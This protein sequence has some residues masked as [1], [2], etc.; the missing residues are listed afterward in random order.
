MQFVA[1]G[2]DVPE[3]LLQAH[4]DGRVVFFCGAGISYPAGL[5]GF[6]GL[7]EEIYNRLGTTKNAIEEEAFKSEK[8]DATLDLLERRMPGQR[9]KVRS[10]L[11]AALK[12]NLRLKAATSTHE[13]LLRLARTREGTLRLVTTNFDR[14]FDAAA[15][16]SKQ[17]LQTFTAPMLPIPKR[18][19]WNGLVALHGAMPHEPDEDALN[20][21][22]VTSGDF[23]LAYLTER[24]AA[25]FVSE[26]FRN[27][28]VCF[29]G[30]SINDPVLRYMMDALAADRMLGETTLQ[31]WAFGDC[32]PGQEERKTTEWKAKGVTPILYKVM[33]NDYS[34][35]RLHNTLRSWSETYRDG[36]TGKMRMVSVNALARPSSSTKEDDFIGR[37]LWALADKTGAPARQFAELNPVPPLEWLTHAFSETRFRHCDLNRFG[38]PAPLD[39]DEELRFSLIDRP[40]PHGL[41]PRM[42]LASGVMNNVAMDEV[43]RHLSHWLVRHLNDPQLLMWVMS[44]GGVLHSYL[45][46]L[47]EKRLDDLSFSQRS[48]ASLEIKEILT[49]APNAIPSPEMELLWRILLS[50]R[51]KSLSQ[52]TGLYSWLSRVRTDGMSVLHRLEL[53]ALLAPKLLLREPMSWVSSDPGTDGAVRLRESLNWELVLASNNVRSTLQDLM[54]CDLRGYHP[55][56]IDDFERLLLEALDI[57]SLLGDATN[58]SDRSFRHLPSVVPHPQ[59]RGFRD[60]VTLIELLRDTWLALRLENPSHASQIAVRWFDMPYPA[61]KRLAFFAASQENCVGQNVWGSWLIA[62]EGWWLWSIETRREVLRLIVLQGSQLSRSAGAQLQRAILKGPP[63]DIYRPDSEPGRVKGA[64]SRSMWLL[65]AKLESSGF[66]LNALASKRLNQ[67]SAANPLWRVSENERDEFSSWMS[68]TGDPDFENSIEVSFAPKKKAAL[69]EWLKLPTKDSY[70]ISRDTWSDTCRTRPLNTLFALSELSSLCIWPIERWRE[71]IRAWWDRRLHARLWT[72]A[73]PVVSALPDGKL[74]EIAHSVSSWLEVI[75][76]KTTIKNADQLYA[77]CQRLMRTPSPSASDSESEDEDD[78]LPARPVNDAINHPVGMVTQVLINQWYLQ[79]PRDNE[80][81]PRVLADFFTELADTSVRHYR[82]GRVILGSHLITLY[83]V[84]KSWTERHLLP[85]LSWKRDVFEAKGIWDGFLWSP[86]LYQPLLAA[87]KNDFLQTASHYGDLGEHKQQFAAFFT[88]VA[89]GP[90]EGFS[91]QELR[92]AFAALPVEGLEESAQTLSQALDGA[93]DQREEHWL[94]RVQPFWQQIW[95]KIRELRTERIAEAVAQLALAAGNKF[96]EALEAIFDWLMPLEYSYSVMQNLM[97]SGHCDTYPKESLRLLA[98]V[99]GEHHIFPEDLQQCLEA[100]AISD[101]TLRDTPQF[102]TLNELLQRMR[103]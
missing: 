94:H 76:E 13:A 43:M 28:I 69:V 70:G 39:V 59:N 16:R 51:V 66:K 99:T 11:A 65:L 17:K 12:P 100:I 98:A 25:R 52:N 73:A 91:I 85:L 19:R 74:F 50:G 1:D 81:L 96:P 41:A 60:W 78:S 63:S 30:Y 48:G 84:D 102:R 22:V 88:Y 97:D 61:F 20:R 32:E 54:S 47:I 79:S 29:V 53:R 9:G 4:E 18:T 7:V 82:H 57:A 93:A 68:G 58:R 27:Y 62:D 83:R 64:T 26:L 21:L 31:A 14:L 71:A 44:Q 86:R 24:W 36:I 55:E 72:L 8:F 23:G 10:A 56:L 87:F 5:P 90:V 95:P 103:G 2:P 34:H 75:S 6:K 67:L 37:M 80:G 38:I 15:K 92:S 49:H 45:R 101:P 40:T 35:W 33:P 89:I 46:A 42:R 77:L 3:E